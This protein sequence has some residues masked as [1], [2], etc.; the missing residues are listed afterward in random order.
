MPKKNVLDEKRGRLSLSKQYRKVSQAQGD[1]QALAVEEFGDL[2]R[3]I[4]KY[5]DFVLQSALTL[6][7]ITHSE[8]TTSHTVQT[9]ENIGLL[10]KPALQHEWL[11]T[12]ATVKRLE[13]ARDEL[14]DL[15]T[16]VDLSAGTEAAEAHV[17]KL[18]NIFSAVTEQAGIMIQRHKTIDPKQNVTFA[19]KNNNMV[20]RIIDKFVS[21]INKLKSTFG[22]HEGLKKEIIGGL[23]TTLAKSKSMMKARLD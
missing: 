23:H 21:C 13:T 12:W 2:V 4:E 1:K 3:E 7:G 14:R 9:L 22:F 8:Y 6:H 10:K 5:T 16:K 15:R 18:N 19:E 17:T 20:N 11:T